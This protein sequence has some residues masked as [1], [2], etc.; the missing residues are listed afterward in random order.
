MKKIIRGKGVGIMPVALEI[1]RETIRVLARAIGVCPAARELG[2]PEAEVREA[3]GSE[4]AVEAKRVG[5]L[6]N[7][8]HERFARLV[9]TK[10]KSD[11]E[12]YQEAYECDYQAA[13]SSAYRLRDN[14]GIVSRIVQLQAAGASK[15]VLSLLEKREFLAK[16]VRTPIGSVTEHDPLCQEVKYGKGGEVTRKMPSKLEAIKL[17]ALL[18]KELGDGSVVVNVAVALR[19][20]ME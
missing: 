16:V 13:L 10:G 5:P 9:A 18:A 17:D 20:D 14:V 15:D 11:V 4:I 6:E 1:D 3:L 12:A 8:R 7:Q 2:V 19:L